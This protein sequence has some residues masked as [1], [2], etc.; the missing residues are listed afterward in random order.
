MTTWISRW[1]LPSYVFIPRKPTP[2]G[3]EWHTLASARTPKPG[4]DLARSFTMLGFTETDAYLAYKAFIARDDPL[5]H[6][7]FR[8]D[9]AS[10]LLGADAPEEEVPDH[11]LVKCEIGMIYKDSRFVCEETSKFVQKRCKTCNTY[12][13]V[14]TDCIC[15]PTTG[16]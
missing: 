13:K 8:R 1:T 5:S 6:I 15:D 9:L 7:E 2:E 16:M 4:E 11:K 10:S 14:R 3:Q 12:K